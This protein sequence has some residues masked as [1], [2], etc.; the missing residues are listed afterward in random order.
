MCQV[1]ISVVNILPH[2]ILA[3]ILQEYY[4]AYLMP[5]SWFNCYW[6]QFGS[7]LDELC[8]HSLAFVTLLNIQP[9]VISHIFPEKAAAKFLQCLISPQ[10]ATCKDDHGNEYQDIV[11][12]DDARTCKCYL[13]LPSNPAW[14]DSIIL[15]LSSSVFTHILH[16]AQLSPS[17]TAFL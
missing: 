9:D 13:N 6:M 4:R 15:L 11:S 17:A 2:D 14:Q 8:I 3:C 7:G 12:S 10:M 5:N 16:G 1:Q